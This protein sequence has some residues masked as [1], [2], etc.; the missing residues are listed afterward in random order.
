MGLIRLSAE[1]TPLTACAIESAYTFFVIT[2][3]LTDAFVFAWVHSGSPACEY[4]G[5]TTAETTNSM[6]RRRGGLCDGEHAPRPSEAGRAPNTHDLYAGEQSPPPFANTM[7]TWGG[8]QQLACLGTAPRNR[9]SIMLYTIAVILLVLWALGFAMSVT[10]GGL[11]HL[12]LVAAVVMVL[13]QLI[14]SR[15]AL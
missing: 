8:S 11:V 10:G 6:N 1:V 3:S 12:L 5:G 9:R 15:R 2:E 4:L 7:V 13:Y 14:M